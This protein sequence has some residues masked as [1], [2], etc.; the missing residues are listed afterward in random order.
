MSSSSKRV[1]PKTTLPFLPPMTTPAIV[2]MIGYAIIVFLILL[3]IDMYM[4][5]SDVDGEV[6]QQY[7]FGHRV[8]MVVLLLFPI[9]ISIY[10]VNCMI[11]GNCVLWSWVVALSTLLWA[12]LI[13]VVA[14]S[15]RSLSMSQIMMA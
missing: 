15:T 5:D 14:F 1:Y 13:T 4:Y 7:N 2:T 6:K 9:V 12:I 11:V 3:P 10:S 8:L